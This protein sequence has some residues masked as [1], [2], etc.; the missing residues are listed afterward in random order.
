[1][2][3]NGVSHGFVRAPDGSITAFDPRRSVLTEPVGINL[4][5]AIT[6]DYLDERNV[7]HGFVRAPDGTITEF[8]VSG[9]G[10]GEGQGT[11]PVAINSAGAITGYYVDASNVAHGF[12]RRPMP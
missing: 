1:M 2:D 10:T 12:L 4:A 9:A 8:D 5:G 3:S 7:W 11:I 6:G